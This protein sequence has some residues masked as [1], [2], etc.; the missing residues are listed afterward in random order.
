MTLTADVNVTGALNGTNAVFGS[1]VQ[2]VGILSAGNAGATTGQMIIE[3]GANAASRRWK[4]L[5]SQNVNGDFVIQQSTTQTGSTFADIL[6][7]NAT[8][9]ANFS[10]S[11][12]IQGATPPTSG[13]GTELAWDGTNGY[14]LAFNR[15]SSAYLPLFVQGS[16]LN[17]G[18][19]DGTT[20]MLITSSGNV[21]IGTATDGGYKLNVAGTIR[22]LSATP[23][24]VSMTSN[25]GNHA[26]IAA[27]WTS[28]VGMDMS[29]FPD[30]AQG[31]IDNTYQVTAGQPYGDIYF[32]QNVSGTMT[33][34]MT[35]KADGGRVG[36][37]TTNPAGRL[38]VND[39]VYGEYL[40][41]A[42][43]VIG[44]NQTS[45]YLAWNNAGNITL[46]QVT[47]GAAD[48]GGSGFRLLRIPNT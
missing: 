25:P 41:V 12:R 22:S 42:T 3:S 47:V 31:F 4:L 17:F 19:G 2:S 5:T 20:K 7:F 24:V 23:L 36:I 1:T 16:T 10:N 6:G 15:T 28:G 13:S 27:R 38:S 34:R 40:R 44:G 48:S 8:G 46:Q 33:P 11:L 45:V 14:L 43:G 30:F 32:R 9:A 37:G 18:T 39:A 35:I 29:Y 26:I 21:L